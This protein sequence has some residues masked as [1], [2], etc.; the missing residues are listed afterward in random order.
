MVKA[1]DGTVITAEIAATRPDRETGLMHRTTLA[2]NTGMLFVFPADSP[3]PFW[4]KDTLIPLDM[5]WMDAGKRVIYVEKNA[6]PCPAI[7][8]QC[9]SFGPSEPARYVL[10]ISAGTADRLGIKPGAS[11]SFQIPA[12]VKVTN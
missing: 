4:M 8:L 11:L 10:E 9:P 7:R 5:V 1:P 3:Y 12:T 6:A 2:R